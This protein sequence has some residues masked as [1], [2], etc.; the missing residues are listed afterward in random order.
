MSITTA[1]LT[2]KIAEITNLRILNFYRE[3][4]SDLI[5][6][7]GE[8]LRNKM[9]S[10]LISLSLDI[11][12]LIKN[13][14]HSDQVI[15][16]FPS[17]RE[18]IPVEKLEQWTRC[19][20]FDF[21]SER[22]KQDTRKSPADKPKEKA[23]DGVTVARTNGG[24]ATRSPIDGDGLEAGA[25]TESNE[26]P[27][28]NSAETERSGG[29]A[30]PAAAVRGAAAGHPDESKGE[31]EP[32]GAGDHIK[33]SLLTSEL[34]KYKK[35]SGLSN[36][37]IG[38]DAGV[39]DMTIGTALKGE[40]IGQKSARLIFN[41]INEATGPLNEGVPV[42]GRKP[43]EKLQQ[44]VVCWMARNAL[45]VRQAAEKLGVREYVIRS[46]RNDLT[47]PYPDVLYRLGDRIPELAPE[48]T[49]L[50]RAFEIQQRSIS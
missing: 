40:K 7:S 20:G 41:A 25:S 2:E 29:D 6:I 33:L 42:A 1:E 49:G 14:D 47:I 26:P 45:G 18:L 36:K 43:A 5:M 27:A 15:A 23:P 32:G 34:K 21:T 39:S 3:H 35:A 10:E 9:D 19:G 31:R 30:R 28:A 37:Q 17:I 48:L 16:N 44:I 24:P 22:I 38:A 12:E 8:H 50:L 13:T 46:I 11:I 4:N